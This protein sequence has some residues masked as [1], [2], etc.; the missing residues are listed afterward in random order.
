MEKEARKKEDVITKG[1]AHGHLTMPT[2]SSVCVCR[3][4]GIALA[5]TARHVRHV[6]GSLAEKDPFWNLQFAIHCVLRT[7]ENAEIT[8]PW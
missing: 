8:L 7:H 3:Q 6:P 4:R 5:H 1:L 2:H